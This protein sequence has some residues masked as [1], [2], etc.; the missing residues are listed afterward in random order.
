M[1]KDP[2]LNTIQAIA[3]IDWQYYVLK[4]LSEDKAMTALELKESSMK[5]Y[6]R[7]ISKKKKLGYDYSVDQ[8][9]LKQIKQFKLISE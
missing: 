4:N 1:S 6:R 3:D 9:A 5:C 8:E 7:I 2:I